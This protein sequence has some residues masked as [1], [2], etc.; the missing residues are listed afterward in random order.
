MLQQGQPERGTKYPRSNGGAQEISLD[1]DMLSAPCPDCSILL[2]EATSGSLTSL[3]A[4][5]TASSEEWASLRA[6]HPGTVVIAWRY[7]HR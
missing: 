4:C 2:V 3:C 6:E 7:R 5:G 1:L